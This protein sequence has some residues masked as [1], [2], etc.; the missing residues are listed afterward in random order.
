VD[1]SGSTVHLVGSPLDNVN[2]PFSVGT[3]P[4][5]VLDLSSA[6]IY[7]SAAVCAQRGCAASNYPDWSWIPATAGFLRSQDHVV[8]GLA[9]RSGVADADYGAGQ[10]VPVSWVYDAG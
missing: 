4:G 2:I 3:A 7:L 6:T 1:V 8:V 9:V 10:P 5:M